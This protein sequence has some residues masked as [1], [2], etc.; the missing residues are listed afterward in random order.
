M[1]ICLTLFNPRPKSCWSPLKS[2]LISTEKR[3]L[4]VFNNSCQHIYQLWV[5]KDLIIYLTWI[6]KYL[7]NEGKRWI[8]DRDNK[9]GRSP[10]A[11]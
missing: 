11:P 8:F 4:S 2:V 7:K 3:R 6:F 5:F 9:Y 10:G 1:Q